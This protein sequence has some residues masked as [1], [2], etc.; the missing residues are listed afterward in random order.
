MAPL[1]EGSARRTDLYLKEKNLATDRHLELVVIRTRN[2]RERPAADLHERT[3]EVVLFSRPK[4]AQH[5]SE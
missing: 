5:I 4:N 2:L 1:D 3:L